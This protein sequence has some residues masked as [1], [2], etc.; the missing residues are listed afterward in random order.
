MCIDIDKSIL[1]SNLFIYPVPTVQNT[2]WVSITT[3]SLLKLFTE[4]K[5]VYFENRTKHMRVNIL[6]EENTEFV[7]PVLN[8]LY[9]AGWLSGT[10]LQPGS[11]HFETRPVHRLS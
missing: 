6:C 2:D 9:R 7:L 11:A 3:T 10:G 5:A 4:I 8:I 1:V